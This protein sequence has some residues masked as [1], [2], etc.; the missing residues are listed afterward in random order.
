MVKPMNYQIK[1]LQKHADQRGW[2]VEMLKQDEIEAGQTIKQIYVAT[3]Q[4]GCFRGGHYHLKRIEWFF[5]IGDNVEIHLED[6]GT[7]EHKAIFIV[8]DKPQRITINP[9][10]AHAVINKGNGAAYLFSAQNNIFAHENPDTIE[11]KN[12]LPSE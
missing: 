9:N 2:L 6:V 8:N 5:I 3:I 10:V 1:D 11:Y 12:V 7:K 4:P